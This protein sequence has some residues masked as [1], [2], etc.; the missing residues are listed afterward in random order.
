[1]ARAAK[2]G[3]AQQ[4]YT[5]LVTAYLSASLLGWGTTQRWATRLKDPD[6]DALR[7]M[8]TRARA[9]AERQTVGL[10]VVA[11]EAKLGYKTWV[12]IYPVKE[13]RRWHQALEG[14][15]I[16][17][18]AL[19]TLGLTGQQCRYPHDWEMVPEP[20]EWMNCGHSVVYTDSD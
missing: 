2:A 3:G 18:D 19:F 15:T 10:E 13:P 16:P 14:R 4:A 9:T 17:R 11:D 20:G 1:M 8:L 6:M 5:D 12:R 7:Q